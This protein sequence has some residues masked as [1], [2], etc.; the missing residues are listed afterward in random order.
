MANLINAN[1]T[2]QTIITNGKSQSSAPSSFTFDS[3]GKV[4]PLADKGTLLPSRIFGSPI[5]GLKDLK[6]DVVNIKN[7][8]HGKA[9]D[10]QL[11]RINDVG[12]KLG[13]L[14]LASYLF[15][16]NPLKLS[17]AMEFAG[18]GTFF[19][20]MALWPKLAIQAP[21]KARTGVDIHQKYIDS[22]GRKKMLYQDPQYV[23]TDLYSKEDLD[24][25]G[26][27][28][29]VNENL[30]D[31]DNF[32]KQRAQKTAI[33]GNTLWMMTAGFATPIMSA[34]A[35]NALEKP[36]GRAI[37]KFDLAKTERAV[38]TPEMYGTTSLIKENL[39]NK[40]FEKF[41]KINKDKSLSDETF[42]SKLSSKILGSETS[43]ALKDGLKQEFEALKAAP[44]LSADSAR[45]LLS[46]EVDFS[47]LSESALKAFDEAIAG[48]NFEKASE[49]LA[50]AAGLTAKNQKRAKA[51]YTGNILKILTKAQGEL[52]SS[53]TVGETSDRLLSLYKSMSQYGRERKVFDKYVGARA[54][55]AGSYVANQWQRVSDNLL[56]SLTGGTRSFFNEKELKALANGDYE[57]LG[58][59]LDQLAGSKKYDKF[60]SKLVGMVNDYEEKVGDGFLNT[61]SDR[62]TNPQDGVFTNLSE[63]L[64]KEDFSKMAESVAKGSKDSVQNGIQKGVK[65]QV[66]G[67]RSSFYRIMQAVDLHKS[68]QEGSFGPQLRTAME[69]QGLTADASSMEKLTNACKKFL[70]T[71]TT[72][73][74]IEKLKTAGFDL[75]E[76][77]YKTLMS[78]LYQPGSKTT[79][80]RSLLAHCSESEVDRMLSG[81]NK[82]KEEFRTKIADWRNGITPELSR[83][84]VDSAAQS[85]DAVER[86]DLV[87][88]SVVD[89]FKDAANNR[90]RSNKWLKIFGG[91]MIALTAV[92]VAA[93]FAMGR[94]GKTEKQVEAENKING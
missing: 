24:K 11:G 34:L 87:G 75:S 3:T 31:R 51:K 90:I 82:Y 26:K 53:T 33:Q 70:F 58:R 37:E 68:I 48:S 91:A 17:K 35:C 23:L 29:K 46:G 78:V 66:N 27:G 83:C 54:E 2:N 93:T 76:A 81:F 5:E 39:K 55:G 13:S 67:A 18:F 92:T 89:F 14:A 65:N 64:L 47:T 42:M 62:L 56:N 59:K 41:L 71:A 57:L 80:S 79:I 40:A 28:L 50:N 88:K 63:N 12:M 6:N 21:I 43:S 38:Q 86:N 77:E 25:M 52:T 7:A 15:V 10:H 85:A 36:I 16:K 4:K 30:P 32:I 94:K 9:N 60:I 84:V 61:V 8:A 74:N 45:Q 19:A 20:S 69:A 49:V 73:D 1:L 72:T 44:K 22:Q